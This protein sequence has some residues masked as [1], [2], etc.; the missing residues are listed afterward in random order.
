MNTKML[1]LLYPI[2]AIISVAVMVI[3]GML[4]DAWGISW[5]AVF[6]GGCLMAILSIVIA[7]LKKNGKK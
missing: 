5:I 3:W 4:G 2:I 1:G 7:G 6:I